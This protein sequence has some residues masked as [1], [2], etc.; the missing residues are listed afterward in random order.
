MS[1]NGFWR[2]RGLKAGTL[3]VGGVGRIM[4]CCFAM[5]VQVLEKLLLGNDDE[6]SR[7]EEG[8]VLTSLVIA[9]WW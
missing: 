8:Q 4:R 1:G 7:T 5:E 3:A 6:P 2:L 9:R